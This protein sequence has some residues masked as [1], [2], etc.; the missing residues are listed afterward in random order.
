MNGDHKKQGLKVLKP[1]MGTTNG[2]TNVDHG[3]KLQMEFK[4]C[5]MM[6]PRMEN[7]ANFPFICFYCILPK[8]INRGEYHNFNRLF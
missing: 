4:I 3:W 8:I 6:I 1:R 2:A 5:H 7:I